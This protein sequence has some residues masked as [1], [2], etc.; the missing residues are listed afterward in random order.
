MGGWGDIIGGPRSWARDLSIAVAMALVMSFLGPFGSYAQPIESRVVYCLA[1][2]LAGSAAFWP[3]FRLGARVGARAGLPE[4]FGLAA[5]VALA[6][7]PVTLIVRGVTLALHPGR[8]GPS[9]PVLYFSVLVVSAPAG[10]AM[11]LT[12]RRRAAEAAEPPAAPPRLLERLP[13][14]LRAELLALQA[15]DHYV[16]IH[17]A[18]GSTLLLMR[19]SDAVAELDGLAGMRVH[20]SWWVASGAV[21]GARAEGRRA[22][23]VLTNGLEAPV[24]REQVPLVRRAG[25]L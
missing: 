24:T 15:E 13:P 9:W 23:I 3:A 8:A 7:L 10:V 6:C 20:R 21:A 12:G 14:R 11:Q 4:L 22:V 1:V 5:A 19:M 2:A 25:W 16:R 18:A 17:T